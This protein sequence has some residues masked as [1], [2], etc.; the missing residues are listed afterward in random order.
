MKTDK[1]TSRVITFHG[2]GGVRGSICQP[3]IMKGTR[4]VVAS[5]TEVVGEGMPRWPH[6]DTQD[7][8]TLSDQEI[9]VIHQ[10]CSRL[11]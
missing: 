5:R 8:K 10:M 6:S 11:T 3:I 2:D 9:T 4:E 1:V 7:F